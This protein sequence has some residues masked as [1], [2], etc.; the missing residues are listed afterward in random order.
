MSYNKFGK[1]KEM[2]VNMENIS[3]STNPSL[4]AL[5]DLRTF[6]RDGLNK[7]GN[8]DNNENKTPEYS[9]HSDITKNVFLKYLTK[10]NNYNSESTGD[11]S[12][13]KTQ[14]NN[15]K[16]NS[17]Q[18]DVPSQ[19]SQSPLKIKTPETKTEIN[20][21]QIST[22]SQQSAESPLKI[23]NPETKTVTKSANFNFPKQK[24]TILFELRSKGI[25][26]S[27][28]A[29]DIAKQYGLSY[30]QAQEIFVE[31]NQDKNGIVKEFNIPYNSTVSYLV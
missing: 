23:K 27:L 28:T 13:A 5:S 8:T 29:R 30:I 12:E 10:Y 19:T 22:S 26:S 14:N 31:L 9:K 25:N 20:P 2:C 24:S 3:S 18:I 1:I 11:N 6:F 15:I 4:N 17:L 16:T 7:I 21:L